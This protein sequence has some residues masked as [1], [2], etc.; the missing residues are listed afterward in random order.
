MK[1]RRF[2]SRCNVMVFTFRLISGYPGSVSRFVEQTVRRT[3]HKCD[4]TK[5]IHCSRRTCLLVF[6]RNTIIVAYP[7][8]R[9]FVHTSAASSFR[10]DNSIPREIMKRAKYIWNRL[11]AAAAPVLSRN[12]CDLF[13]RPVFWYCDFFSPITFRNAF[14]RI[15]PSIFDGSSRKIAISMEATTVNNSWITRRDEL[16]KFRPQ[17]RCSDNA[18]VKINVIK[19]FDGRDG[20]YWQSPIL[21]DAV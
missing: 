8:A 7:S 4:L 21:W 16:Q 9:L 3:V 6:A 5:G 12:Y 2:K 10:S 11:C 17:I 1:K 20:L 13:I 14:T 18:S 19:Q 15:A